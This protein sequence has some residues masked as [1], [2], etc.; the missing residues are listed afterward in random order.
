MTCES[1]R[2]AICLTLVGASRC[3]RAG[4]SVGYPLPVC[5]LIN[6]A[7]APTPRSITPACALCDL[8]VF[9]GE[10]NRPQHARDLGKDRGVASIQQSGQFE[11]CICAFR[12]EMQLG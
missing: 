7:L 1:P 2:S 12:S 8:E 10:I 5:G 4:D 6:R 9:V 3:P 11:N